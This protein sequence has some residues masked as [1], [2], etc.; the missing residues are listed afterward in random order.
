MYGKSGAEA[1]ECALNVFLD[2]NCSIAWVSCILNV[3]SY[4]CC[5]LNSKRKMKESL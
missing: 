2:P 1:A 5:C 3:K 4:L